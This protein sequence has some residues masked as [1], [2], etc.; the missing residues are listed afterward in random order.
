MDRSLFSRLTF[1]LFTICL[2]C[3][4][5]STR[6]IRKERIYPRSSTDSII[7]ILHD[8]VN[9]FQEL[10]GR[11]S[12]HVVK[13]GFDVTF[14][15]IFL[16]KKNGFMQLEVYS[17]FGILT[18]LLVIDGDRFRLVGQEENIEGNTFTPLEAFN[19]HWGIV[20][21]PYHILALFA[22]SLIDPYFY[23]FTGEAYLNE[24]GMLRLPIVCRQNKLTESLYY[25][26]SQQR[27]I[28]REIPTAQENDPITVEYT[29][30]QPG[31]AVPNR[32]D[33]FQEKR[34]VKLIVTLSHLVFNTTDSQH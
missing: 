2:V 34:R 26:S 27:I 16:L 12:V 30:D 10:K 18:H 31:S 14:E 7:T 22:G 19:N 6:I 3:S 4:C 9:N 25:D 20:V 5:A 8:K 28:N 24:A 11:F 29:Y 33:V 1:C 23:R 21:A 15:G 32:I 13:P 17:P